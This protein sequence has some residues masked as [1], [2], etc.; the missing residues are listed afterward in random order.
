MMLTASR[1][2]PTMEGEDEKQAWMMSLEVPTIPWW[3]LPVYQ[4]RRACTN[5]FHKK[6]RQVHCSRDRRWSLNDKITGDCLIASA[7]APQMGTTRAAPKAT[8][9]SCA[10]A[11]SK[12]SGVSDASILSHK[13]SMVLAQNH[14]QLP[15]DRPGAY[16]RGS[17]EKASSSTA[18]G[19]RGNAFRATQDFVKWGWASQYGAGSRHALS[20][21]VFVLTLRAARLLFKMPLRPPR[22]VKQ[23]FGL[24]SLPVCA[25]TEKISWFIRLR[26][27]QV[28]WQMDSC[29]DS[30]TAKSTVQKLRAVLLAMKW[31]A[32]RKKLASQWL[33]V[34]SQVSSSS[35]ALVDVLQKGRAAQA[36]SCLQPCTE[37]R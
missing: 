9:A 34:C 20:S 15:G 18:D 24:K 10:D 35:S 22:M 27:A 33:L 6:W 26:L 14:T 2:K 13:G 25:S 29:A 7:L 36:Y 8:L 4:C 31:R 5:C 23:K 30:K 28:S 11:S 16:I 32:R 37:G 17:T 1:Q 3:L 21:V 19:I 12:A